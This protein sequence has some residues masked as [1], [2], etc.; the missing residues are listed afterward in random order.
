M[1]VPTQTLWRVDKIKE[2]MEHF[3]DDVYEFADRIGAHVVEVRRW[4]DTSH[5]EALN[6]G[7]QFKA[8]LDG[9]TTCYRLDPVLDFWVVT[10]IANNPET[11]KRANRACTHRTKIAVVDGAPWYPGRRVTKSDF[12]RRKAKWV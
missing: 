4:L 2:L 5:N 6:R 11:A 1:P 12:K 8:L 10:E 7:E 3:G 9:P